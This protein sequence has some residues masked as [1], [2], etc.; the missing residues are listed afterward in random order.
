[1]S[2]YLFF[3]QAS[4]EVDE[5]KALGRTT[6]A[7]RKKVTRGEL[8]AARSDIVIGMA[9]GQLIMY[10]IVAATAATLHVHGET[11]IATAAQAAKALEPLAGPF[12]TILFSI[13]LIG[14]G[15][16]AIPILSGSAAYAIKEFSGLPGTLAVKPRYRPTFYGVIAVATIAGLVFNLLGVNPIAALFITAVINGLVAPPLLVLIVLLG[17]DRKLMGAWRSRRLSRSL[18]WAAAG[19][20]G[21]AATALVFSPLFGRR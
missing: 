18:T 12:A 15:L 14:T 8:R 11:H 2:P 4:S 6:L 1:M 17:S 3:W 13:G 7:E 5:M 16:L 9:F 10:C 19:A 21:L 20:M